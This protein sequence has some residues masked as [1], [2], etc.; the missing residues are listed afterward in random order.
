MKLLFA[1]WVWIFI[2]NVIVLIFKLFSFSQDQ[3]CA[4]LTFSIW[5]KIFALNAL[6][7]FGVL[8][9]FS[10]LNKGFSI[11]IEAYI[12]LIAVLYTNYATFMFRYHYNFNKFKW[13]NG[14]TLTII[15]AEKLNNIVLYQKNDNI[16]KIGFDSGVKEKTLRNDIGIENLIQLFAAENS[17]RVNIKK[18][19]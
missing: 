18:R 3:N 1:I 13:F 14:L 16:Y 15:K 17:I 2:I 8:F 7:F 11:A 19:V 4:K 6:L 10:F 9:V 12:M 5:G